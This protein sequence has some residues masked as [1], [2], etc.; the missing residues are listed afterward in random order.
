MN[1]HVYLRP[2]P[3]SLSQTSR[4]RAL[5]DS[6]IPKAIALLPRLMIRLRL[7]PEQLIEKEFNKIH[8]RVIPVLAC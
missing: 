8:L 2:F 1:F 5:G 4:R 3:K 6:E 7:K